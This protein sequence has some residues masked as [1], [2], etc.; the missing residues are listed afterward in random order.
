MQNT[1]VLLVDD[2]SGFTRLIKLGLER[3]GFVVQEE[4]DGTRACLAARKF[5]PD[6]IFLD[7]V[8]PKIDG[9]E[10]AREIRADLQLGGVPIVFLTA[11]VARQEARRDIGG[12]PFLAKP[13]SLDSITRC[14]A[15]HVKPDRDDGPLAAAIIPP[16]S[17]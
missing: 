16:V 9:G 15:E 5:N 13:V 3:A 2:Q 7:I 1:R 6:I 12:W 11:I 17:V 8:M 4:N 14:I 10:V